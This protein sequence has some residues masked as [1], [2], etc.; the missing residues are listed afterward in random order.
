M[1][2]ESVLTVN[3]AKRT[4]SLARERSLL[5]VLREELG[6]TAAKYGCGEGSCGACTVLVEGKPVRAC[7]VPV[8]EAA[9]REVDTVEGLSPSGGLHPVQQAFLEL[10]A[11]QCGYCTP[12]M[13]LGAIALL[14]SNPD[15]DEREI[16]LAL[17]G[18]LC[19]CC[20]YPRIVQ[21]VRRAA[22]LSRS[23]P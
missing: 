18:H 17:D 22:E 19:R 15:P 1:S 23:A 6:L 8:R 5:H 20:A 11:M 7:V 12:G 2:D 13:I 21:A 4:I 9:G 14:R 10:N 16:A 3:G